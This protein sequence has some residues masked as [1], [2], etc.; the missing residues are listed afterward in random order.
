MPTDDNI[1]GITTE[2]GAGA[3]DKAQ[4]SK[5]QM[6][7]RNFLRVGTIAAAGVSLVDTG[8]GSGAVRHRPPAASRPG[9]GRRGRS[10]WSRRRA[11]R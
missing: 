2:A 10:G 4:T 8:T 3:S 5:G 6:S 7:R 11:R 1:L 9:G